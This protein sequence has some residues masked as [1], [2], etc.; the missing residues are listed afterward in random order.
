MTAV[1]P[2]SVLMLA[3]SYPRG[4][5][6]NAA[7]FLRLLA[8]HLDA[9]GVRV[10]VIA[11]AD[12][13]VGVA[14][15]GGVRVRRFSYF[16]SPWRRLAYG[17]GILS[18]LARNPAL[19]LQVPFFILS[20]TFVTL[21]SIARN[22]PDVVHA[23]W[24][25]PQGL[26][27][28]VARLFFGTPVVISAH[29]SD[30]FVLKG[31]VL[32]WIKRLCLRKSDAW[33]SNTR[34]TSIALGAVDSTPEPRIIPMGVDVNR[35]SA[36]NGDELRRGLSADTYV[37]LFVGRLVK[38]KGVDDLVRAYALLPGNLKTG[39]VL[40]VVGTGDQEQQLRDLAAEFGIED[41]VRFW[42]S[43]P[44][45]QLP[46]FYA[47]AD[48]FVGPS[49]EE[50]QG[51]VFLEAFAARTCVLATRAGGIADVVEHGRTG[52][53]VEPG[54]PDEL[55]E[56]MAGLLSDENRRAALAANAFE[57][58][59]EVYSWDKVAGEFEA[60]YQDVSKR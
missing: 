53:L 2:L 41:R 9:R 57:Q 7:I 8:E 35:F 33:T 6:D 47:A 56:A 32:A 13:S 49:V 51:V 11:P 23:H 43:V 37:V 40:W 38:I 12:A 24:V 36:G 4:R 39:S 31:T 58:A 14:S 19:W 15:E 26:V 44:N 5:D 1:K 17:S 20:M 25:I 30:A 45:D 48:L 22:R 3:S 34:L 29:G 59:S 52:I 46:H 27:A 42:G 21:R 28:L 50:G 10:G 18:N 54:S 16:P 60:V 55:A